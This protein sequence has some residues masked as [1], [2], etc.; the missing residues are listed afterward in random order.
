MISSR[1][2]AR[3]WALKILYQADVA[4][5]SIEESETVA[6]ERLRR[7][8]VQRSS[9]AATGSL[10]EEF[11]VD[12]VT[13][14]LRDSLT[15]FDPAIELGLRDCLSQLFSAPSFWSELDLELRFSRQSFAVLW[16]TPHQRLAVV[17]P[18]DLAELPPSM[19]RS[20]QIGSTERVRLQ[21]FLAWAR[22]ALPEAA[23]RAFAR[24][25]QLACPPGARL[26]VTHEFV[27]DRW[28]QFSTD[29]AD[30]W[31]PAGSVVARQ[32]SDWIRVAGF[33]TMLVSGVRQHGRDIDRILQE[34]EIGWSMDRQVSVD[35]NILRMAAFELLYL[36]TIPASATINEAVELAKKYST[37]E[38]GRFV[39]GVLGAMV[40]RTEGIV[41]DPLRDVV[42]ALSIE[43]IPVPEVELEDLADEEELAHA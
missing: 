11:L 8:F 29:M 33:T 10:L 38:S 37:S 41:V 32:T 18:L 20:Q 43:D 24:E 17:L 7:E 6:Q 5:M 30:R 21:R 40:A 42:Q 34:L 26:K 14:H 35:R 15:A 23:M 4:R 22:S 1:R 39:N 28:R 36:T 31:S 9:R 2:L 16:E 12:I 13:A 25:T 19:A 3:E 27:L